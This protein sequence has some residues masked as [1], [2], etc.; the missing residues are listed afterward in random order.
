MRVIVDGKIFEY[1]VSGDVE[2]GTGGVLLESDDDLI[3]GKPWSAQGFTLAPFLDPSSYSLLCTGV[4]NLVMKLLAKIGVPCDDDFTLES[5]HRTASNL[6]HH[7]A[8]VR[9]VS[10]CFPVE[11]M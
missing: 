7:E 9:E 5:Y 3:A 2:V 4:R 6:A 8:I 10:P 1:E 11:E